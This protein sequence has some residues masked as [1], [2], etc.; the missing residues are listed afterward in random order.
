MDIRIAYETMLGLAAEMTLDEALRKY[1][2][3]QLYGEIDHALE[4]GDSESFL[5]LTEE[6]KAIL[7]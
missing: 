3:E 4:E 5:R 7:H 6:L 2:K 1:R